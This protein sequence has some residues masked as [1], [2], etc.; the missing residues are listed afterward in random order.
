M[1]PSQ[2]HGSTSHALN[3]AIPDWRVRVS[4]NRVSLRDDFFLLNSLSPYLLYAISLVLMS[5]S[6]GDLKDR[7]RSSH[8]SNVRLGCGGW[9][10]NGDG[11][12]T[13]D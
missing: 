12:A 13:R 7:R 11:A 4:I 2:Y 10:S 3:V 1:T 9:L 5:G 6:S 8:S